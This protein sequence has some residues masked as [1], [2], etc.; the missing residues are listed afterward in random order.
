LFEGLKSSVVQLKRK[1]SAHRLSEELYE[2]NGFENIDSL[3]K[4]KQEVE[5]ARVEVRQSAEMCR[6]ERERRGAAD[7]RA[8][9]AEASAREV[10][11][12]LPTRE[13]V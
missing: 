6:L 5:V 13:M 1:R 11:T 7:A 12:K 9:N 2:V 8:N 4:A 10:K 3:E